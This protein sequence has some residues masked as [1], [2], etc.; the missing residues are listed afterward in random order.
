MRGAAGFAGRNNKPLNAPLNETGYQR[1]I[2]GLGSRHD[3]LQGNGAKAQLYDSP[4][5]H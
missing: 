3:N 1:G 5:I 4:S 2:G